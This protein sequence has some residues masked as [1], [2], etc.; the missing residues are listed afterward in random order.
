MSCDVMRTVFGS[1]RAWWL[2]EWQSASAG[3]H[4]AVLAVALIGI[5]P[6]D[7]VAFASTSALMAFVAALATWVPARQAARVNPMVTFRHE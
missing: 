2:W 6:F 1:S 4:V 3:A 7:L 5:E